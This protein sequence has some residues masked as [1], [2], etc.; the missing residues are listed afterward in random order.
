MRQPWDANASARAPQRIGY[1]YSVE[2][3]ATL[4]REARLNAG[5]SQAQLARRLGVSQAAVAK[6]EQPS[7]NPTVR[8][9]ERV[10]GATGRALSLKARPTGVDESL[11]REQLALTP[12]Q[13]L[14]QLEAMYEWGR[15]LS[16]AGAR[17]RGELD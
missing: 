7:A 9:L 8:T 15:E 2:S 6:L 12:E 14:A 13:R 5:L 4:I 10:L 11:I 3:A 1:A 16:L 17:A